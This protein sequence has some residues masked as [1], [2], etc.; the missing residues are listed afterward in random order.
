MA[1]EQRQKDYTGTRHGFVTMVNYDLK[2]GGEPVIK[3]VKQAEVGLAETM[4]YKPYVKG[5]APSEAK[6]YNP[7][8]A[9][10]LEEQRAAKEK[11]DMERLQKR[12][13]EVV[14]LGGIPDLEAL[15]SASE[16]DYQAAVAELQAERASK[17]VEGATEQAEPKKAGRPKAA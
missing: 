17:G 3:Q 11:T 12:V 13:V 4:G 6:T 7:A 16:E 2:Q 14:Q 15:K 9:K 10:A 1:N 8:L 5:A